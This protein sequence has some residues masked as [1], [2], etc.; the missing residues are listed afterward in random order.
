MIK[1]NWDKGKNKILSQA[2]EHTGNQVGD[3]DFSQTMNLITIQTSTKIRH[4]SGDRISSQVMNRIG[5][6]IQ[7]N[8]KES[9][10]K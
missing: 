10:P 2:L 4:Q 1:Q 6:L 7:N 8:L 3:N 9:K 5:N